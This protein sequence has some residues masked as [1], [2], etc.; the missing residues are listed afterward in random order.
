MSCKE[1]RDYIIVRDVRSEPQE[2][3]GHTWQFSVQQV[4]VKEPNG[5]K[6][7][8]IRFVYYKDN[9]LVARP[10]TFVLDVVVDTLGK[11]AK[12]GILTGVEVHRQ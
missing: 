5:N 2:C 8:A 4:L 10:P 12:A 9:R 11:A 3:G 1:T 6:W 7:E